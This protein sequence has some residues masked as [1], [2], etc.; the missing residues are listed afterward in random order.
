MPLTPIATLPPYE[1]MLEYILDEGRECDC[2]KFRETCKGIVVIP[3]GE[4]LFPACSRKDFVE[5]LSPRMVRK[6]YREGHDNA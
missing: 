2:C 1:E 6:I 3:G 4:T 5:L